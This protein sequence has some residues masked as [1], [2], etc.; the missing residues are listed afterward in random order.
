MTACPAS[1]NSAGNDYVDIYS[2]GWVDTFEQKEPALPRE[3]SIE[4]LYPDR[5]EYIVTWFEMVPRVSLG[6]VGECRGIV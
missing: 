2:S 5:E 1:E 4:Y 3:I 6:L